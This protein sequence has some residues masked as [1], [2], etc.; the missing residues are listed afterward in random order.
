VHEVKKGEECGL[1]LQDFDTFENGDRIECYYI[2]KVH[3]KL[4]E[5]AADAIRERKEK[6]RKQRDAK[7]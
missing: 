2:N 5:R 7:L 4:G 6:E 1:L 3:T